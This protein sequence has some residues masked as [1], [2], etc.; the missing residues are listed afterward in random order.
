VRGKI[1][2]LGVGW[3]L[4]ILFSWGWETYNS[5]E[6]EAQS[7]KEVG[8][9]FFQQIV[10]TREW[11]A[12]HGGVYAFVDISTAPNPYLK[13]PLRDIKL[14]NGRILT[15]INPAYMTRQL[16][17]IAKEYDGPQVHITSLKPIR[18]K[19]RP[20]PWER[21]VLEAFE[22]GLKEYGAFFDKSYRYMAPLKTEISCLKC[23]QE[24]GYKLGDIRGGISLTIPYTRT[25]LFSGVGGHLLIAVI[26]LFFIFFIGKQLRKA[27]SSMEEQSTVDPLTGLYNRRYFMKRADEEYHRNAREKLP[28]SIIMTDID[29][30]KRYNDTY[31]H[32]E[33]DRCLKE[34]AEVMQ[35]SLK[36]AGDCIARYGGEE[37]VIMLPNTPLHSAKQFAEELRSKIEQLQIFNVASECSD[38]V[39]VSFGVAELSE[40]MEGELSYETL[41]QKADKALYKAKESGRNRVEIFEGENE[42]E[43]KE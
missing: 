5:R 38:V 24:Q 27:Y 40:L 15:L 36:R 25:S 1:A 39:T 34:V 10:L 22:S 13:H 6:D 21:P 18:P 7:L 3:I 43:V 9:A 16:S 19:N 28:L 14:E 11:N 20:K 4:V 30:F 32:V 37:F 26:G 33:G 17:E 31:G 35:N 41:I 42:S 8:R 29:Y 12:R 2:L 23:H